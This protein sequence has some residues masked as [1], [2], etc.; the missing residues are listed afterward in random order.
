VV[1]PEFAR[2]CPAGV[3][4][5]TTRVLLTG[6]ATRESF[7]RMAS[8]V[9]RAA[10]ELATAE[11]DVVVYGCTS[12]S[13]GGEGPQA[14]ATIERICGVPAVT[15]A[16]AVVE[17]LAALGVRRIAVATPYVSSVNETER[18]FLEQAGLEVVSIEGMGIGQTDTDRRTIAH[19]PPARTEALARAVD[20][21]EAEAIFISCTNLPTLEIIAT[22]EHDLGKPVVTSNTASLWA[23]MQR[24]GVRDPIQGYG[25]L[26]E[27]R[28]SPG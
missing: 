15:T 7:Q 4:W 5:H 24:V 6:P 26:L 12:G 23:A 2:L 9:A 13:I 18:S 27:Q 20:R 16:G 14:V 3:S 17:A 22:L 19:Q 21:P 8:N 28:L 11:V 10:E 25:C 1:D